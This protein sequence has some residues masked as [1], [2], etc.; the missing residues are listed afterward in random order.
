MA[1]VRWW[2]ERREEILKFGVVGGVA[3]VVDLGLFNLLRFGPHALLADKIV[4]AKV[5]SA[6]VATV[7][8]WLGNRLWTFRGRRTDH[9]LDE[10]VI[11]GVINVFALFIPVGTVA[12]TAYALDQR[13]ALATNIAAVIGIGIGTVVRYVGYRHFVF[14]DRVALR[15]RLVR[16]LAATPERLLLSAVAIVLAC[17]VT[18]SLGVFRPWTTIP[19][20]LVLGAIGWRFVPPPRRDEASARGSTWLLGGA[21]VWVFVNLPWVAEYVIVRRDPGFLTLTGLWLVHHGSTD[22]PTAGALDAA[23]TNDAARTGAPDAWNLEGDVIQPQG[24]KLLPAVLAVGG[25]LGGDTGVFMA[26]LVVGALGL[27]AIYVLAREVMGPIGALV[28]ALALSL[29]VS[30]IWLSRAAYTEPIVMLLLVTAIAWGWRGVKE[31]RAPPLLLAAVASGATTLARIDGAAYALGLL[32]GVTV[33][34]LAVRERSLRWKAGTLASFAALQAATVGSGYASVWRWSRA[35]A[36]RLD[37]E[38]GS[39]TSL[40]V[41]AIV[42]VLV[43]ALGF[44][45]GAILMG[46]DYRA[47]TTGR[48]APRKVVPAVA[49]GLVV[50]TFL[51]LASRPFWMTAH[52]N[53]NPPYVAWLQ[54]AEG[55]PVDGTR[56]YAESTVT[57]MSYY[58]T[59]PILLLGVAG[60]AIAAWRWGRGGRGWA[61]PLAGFLAPTVLY[62]VRPSIVPDQVWAIRRLSASGITGFV[63]AAAIGGAAIAAR[64]ARRVHREAGRTTWLGFAAVIC[65]APVVTWFPFAPGVT[66]SPIG[67][68]S[69]L[70]V[71]E[72]AGSRAQLDT[73]CAY[74]DERPVLLVGT[75]SHFGTIRIGCDV[76]VVTIGAAI[77]APSLREM[78]EAWGEPFVVVTEHPDFVPWVSEPL[79]PTF[80]SDAHYSLGSL[81]GFSIKSSVQVFRWY[82]GTVLPDGTVRLY[83]GPPESS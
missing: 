38:V 79:T 64:V 54:Q 23:A 6:A 19:L 2:R 10:L 7:V 57:W 21:F 48:A 40:Y 77:D 80:E 24:A 51:V 73:L 59:W 16:F 78:G 70:R 41:V 36:S 50:T 26:N 43:I 28:P 82:I 34:V 74:I 44:A 29:T 75:T 49:A 18:V 14:S 76:P 30:H 69:A 5:V 55:D 39:L 46:R 37:D 12:F 52:G 11:Y 62:L 9:P 71:P 61:V 33:G 3:F 35:Y 27:V 8:A 53:A 60:F 81:Q 32:F 25:W 63:F 20:A 1:V 42:L 13:G 68:A 17:G 47:T 58:L 22:I 66:A 15:S 45:I 83:S 65:L 67:W 31:G 4:T 72:Q 56:T